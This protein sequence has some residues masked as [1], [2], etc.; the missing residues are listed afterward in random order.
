MSYFMKFFCLGVLEENI[1]VIQDPG[2][3]FKKRENRIIGASN[4]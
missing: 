3:L 1:S 4:Q 2:K